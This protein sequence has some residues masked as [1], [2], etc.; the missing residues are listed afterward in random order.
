MK[1]AS[2]LDWS[3]AI[4]MALTLK[5]FIAGN[6]I[7]SR[8]DMRFNLKYL[9]ECYKEFA[10]IWNLDLNCESFQYGSFQE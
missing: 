1:V 6:C 2:L 3:P 5:K 4:S 8:L 7:L 9:K 10:E